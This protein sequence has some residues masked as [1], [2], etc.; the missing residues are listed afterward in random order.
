MTLGGNIHI[1]G[2]HFSEIVGCA[3]FVHTAVLYIA[4]SIKD[5][6]EVNPIL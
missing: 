6:N 1:E 3:P 2:N 4:V 5:V